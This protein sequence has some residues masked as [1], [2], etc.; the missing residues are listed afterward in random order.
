LKSPSDFVTSQSR[1]LFIVS[2][3]YARVSEKGSGRGAEKWQ[4]Q[5][6]KLEEEARRS[7][8]NGGTIVALGFTMKS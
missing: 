6:E 5:Q 1:V 2:S 7:S 4:Y 8:N 3:L